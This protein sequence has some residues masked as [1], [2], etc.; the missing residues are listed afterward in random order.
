MRD[1]GRHAWNSHPAALV[2]ERWEATQAAAIAALLEDYCIVAA[3]YFVEEFSCQENAD[4]VACP[5]GT[6]IRD[7]IVAGECDDK[8]S[9]GWRQIRV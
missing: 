8:L 4:I 9:G 5:V 3:L 1:I 7:F 2:I 6:Y